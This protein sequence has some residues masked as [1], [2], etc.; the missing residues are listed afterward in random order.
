[1][2]GLVPPLPLRGR[3]SR[4]GVASVGQ[5][6]CD[7]VTLAGQGWLTYILSTIFLMWSVNGYIMF[8]VLELD[9][10]GPGG[11]THFDTL[12]KCM[13]TDRIGYRSM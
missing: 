11:S 12:L 9:M 7:R 4:Q 8:L 13:N 3:P 6:G 1:M 2:G 10:G 5:V